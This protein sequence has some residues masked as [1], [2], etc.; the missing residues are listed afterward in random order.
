MRMTGLVCVAIALA[1]PLA[2]ISAPSTDAAAKEGVLAAIARSD[3]AM[4]RRDLRTVGMSL[5]SD[6]V[7]YLLDGSVKHK[8]EYVAQ[9]RGVMAKLPANAS[10]RSKVMSMKVQAGGVVVLGT[11]WI[12]VMKVDNTGVKHKVVLGEVGRE[13]WVKRNGAW[14]EKQERG[15]KSWVEVDGKAVKPKI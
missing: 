2:S 11:G 4:N 6:Y 14:V 12:T 1:Q 9:L 10:F 3:A 8:A 13:F 7:L 5:G 15:I